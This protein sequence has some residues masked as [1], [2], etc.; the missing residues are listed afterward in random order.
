MLPRPLV[1]A[2]TVLIALAWTANVVIGF[3]TPDRHDPALNGIFAIVVG[4]VYALGS[5]H[6]AMGNARRKLVRILKDD[7]PEPSEDRDEQP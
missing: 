4:A 1:T 3:V 7:E 5:K 2:L 6:D